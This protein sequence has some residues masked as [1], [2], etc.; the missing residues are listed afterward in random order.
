MK[1]LV[2]AHQCRNEEKKYVCFLCGMATVSP[3]ATLAKVFLLC[4]KILININMQLF[5]VS[6]LRT[7]AFVMQ[8]K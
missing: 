6:L 5:S 3:F 7:L 2:Q 1:L 4:I 8:I